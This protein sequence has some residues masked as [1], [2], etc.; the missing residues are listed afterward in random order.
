MAWATSMSWKTPNAAAVTA[1]VGSADAPAAMA[2]YNREPWHH[3]AK[4]SA[5]L[6]AGR[7]PEPTAGPDPLAPAVQGPFASASGAVLPSVTGNGKGCDLVAVLWAYRALS[8]CRLGWGL[9]HVD[10]P[11]VLGLGVRWRWAGVVALLGLG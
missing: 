1:A 3:S 11:A 5:Q 4:L 10:L 9:W 6:P 8:R 7:W 2:M